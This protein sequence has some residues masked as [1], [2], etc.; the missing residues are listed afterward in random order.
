MQ[1]IED[2]KQKALSKLKAVLQTAFQKM[3]CDWKKCWPKCFIFNANNFE[4]YNM[5]IDKEIRTFP[6]KHKLHNSICVCVYMCTH[7]CACV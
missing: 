4:G 2:I 5:N 7:A 1:T 3:F 6:N